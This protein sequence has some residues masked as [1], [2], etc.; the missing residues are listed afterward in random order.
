MRTWSDWG[1]WG[2]AEKTEWHRETEKLGIG[3]L[4]SLMTK[5]TWH[6]GSLACLCR[7][8]QRWD[9]CIQLSEGW[10]SH[11]ENREVGFMVW[12]WIKGTGLSNQGQTLLRSS[13]QSVNIWKLWWPFLAHYQHPHMDQ[14]GRFCHFPLCFTPRD[15]LA[16]FPMI[17]G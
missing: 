12:S 16:T 4:V 9:Y 17:W 14:K 3:D 8:E 1:Q 7:D 15:S 10:S 11:T 13:L 5:M 2:N 6:P